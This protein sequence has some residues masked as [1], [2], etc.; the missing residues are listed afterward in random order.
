MPLNGRKTRIELDELECAEECPVSLLR[1]APYGPKVRNLVTEISKAM[2][3][4]EISGAWPGGV[5]SGE[6]DAHF[7]DAVEIAEQE[8]RRLDRAIDEAVEGVRRQMS[9]GGGQ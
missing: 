9:Q 3:V 7:Y 4:K 5:D 6:W 1:R 2:A 8:R